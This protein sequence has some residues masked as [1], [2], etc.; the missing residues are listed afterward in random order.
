MRC[1]KNL[2]LLESTDPF[3]EVSNKLTSDEKTL[4]MYSPGDKFSK[5]VD[6]LTYIRGNKDLMGLIN[7][8]PNLTGDGLLKEIEKVCPNFDKKS[9]EKILY[10]MTQYKAADANIVANIQAEQ[11]QKLESP[12]YNIKDKLQTY[13]NSFVNS[14]SVDKYF[15]NMKKGDPLTIAATGAVTVLSGMGLY[16]LAK[17]WKSYRDECLKRD[18][19]IK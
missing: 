4:Y 8:N 5:K 3:E 7:N 1:R 13:W 14:E 6:T 15:S 17:K 12:L 9:R 2:Y 11:Q 19:I 10:A 16:W 18:G